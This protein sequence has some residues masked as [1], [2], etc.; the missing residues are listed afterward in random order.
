MSIPARKRMQRHFAELQKIEEHRSSAMEKSLQKIY[1]EMLTDLQGFIGVEYARYA[2]DDKLTYA[3]LARKN[4]YARFL[5][6]VQAKV[7]GIIPQVN[8]EITAT[9][10]EV[11]KIAYEGMV[12]AVSIAV[13]DEQLADLLSGVKLTPAQVIKAAVENPVDKLTLT[14]TLEKNRKTIVHNI[15]QTV[16]VGIMNGDRMSTMAHKIQEDV[17]M[18]YRKAMNIARTEV[19]R[20]RETGHDDAANN[21]DKILADEDYEYRMVKIWRSKQDIATRRTSKANHVKM[22]GQTVLQD[23]EFDLGDCKARCPGRTGKAHHDCR[24]RCRVTRKLMSDAEFF[25]ATG[26]HFKTVEEP[27]KPAPKKRKTTKKPKQTAQPETI[28]GTLTL[29]NFPTSFTQRTAKKQTKKFVDYVNG[30]EN[31]DSGII[32]LYGNIGKMESIESNGVPFKISYKKSGH[33]VSSRRRYDGTLVDAAL[34]IPKLDAD[35]ITGAVQTTAHELGHLMDM[36]MRTDKSK[37]RGWFSTTKNVETAI[38]KSRSGISDKIS[39]LFKSANEQIKQ[40]RKDVTAK[41]KGMVDDLTAENSEV[42]RDWWKHA[43]EYKAY[44]K[45][46]KALYKECEEAIDY[47]TRNALKGMNSLQDIYDA[48]SAG[49]YRDTGVVTYGHGSRYYRDTENQTLEIWANYCALS[50]T[51]PDLIDLLR[52]DKPELVAA[53]DEVKE[54]ILRK[55]R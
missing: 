20:V 8:K 33:S 42:V 32:E 4:E 39:G 54:A 5:E 38:E 18:N 55:M 28:N 19:H 24:C 1:K 3:V 36:Y 48:L 23:E 16:T 9:V 50:L 40:I 35:N 43:T 6:E 51:R 46:R 11:Y 27:E 26:R 2:E 14:K 45:K 25:E 34:T 30:L 37:S 22:H 47:E 44:E 31:A 21:L 17:D 10:Q 15:K 13:D 49:K 41:Y 7:N 29:D 12:K 52:K 53:L